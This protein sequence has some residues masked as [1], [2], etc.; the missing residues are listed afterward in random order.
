M[1]EKHIFVTW[2]TPTLKQTQQEL[3]LEALWGKLYLW[4]WAVQTKVHWFDLSFHFFSFLFILTKHHFEHGLAF[5]LCHKRGGH[6]TKLCKHVF[7]LLNHYYQMESMIKI[8]KDGLPV[9]INCVFGSLSWWF[10]TETSLASTKW[11]DFFEILATDQLL[12]K[13][14]KF[15]KWS[16]V[17]SANRII[18]IILL[19][20]LKQK[21]S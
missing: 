20:Q 5:Y 1:C 15:W 19:H 2:L 21:K 4:P 7:L 8:W 9:C 6:S 10:S 12:Q 13:R 3:I 18:S 11:T 14:K 17:A 16:S